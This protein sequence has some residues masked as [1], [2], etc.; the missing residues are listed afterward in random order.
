MDAWEYARLADEKPDAEN[1]AHVVEALA[2]GI[3]EGCGGCC[4][5]ILPMTDRERAR[6]VDYSRSHHVTPHADASQMCALLEPGTRR[7]MAYQARPLVCRVWD[8]P[9]HGEVVGTRPGQPCGMRRDRVRMFWAHALE[10]RQTD[11]WEL[12]GLPEREEPT[13]QTDASR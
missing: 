12:F 10:Y 3:C 4:G 6:L 11:T 5:R 7:C 13:W 2:S 1:G 8:S 9:A